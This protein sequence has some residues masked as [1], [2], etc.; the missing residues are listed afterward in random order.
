MA[1]DFQRRLDLLRNGMV[2]PPCLFLLGMFVT[3]QQVL[4]CLL[5]V[6]L[7]GHLEVPVERGMPDRF[8]ALV[9]LLP[10]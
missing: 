1:D 2:T 4:V 10:A 7:S 9:P 8:L 3:D 6:L 5:L